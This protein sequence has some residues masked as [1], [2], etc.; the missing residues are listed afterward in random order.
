M[1]PPP[2]RLLGLK[3]EGEQVCPDQKKWETGTQ[4]SPVFSQEGLGSP[5][6]CSC[7]SKVARGGVLW[8]Q[9]L[10]ALVPRLIRQAEADPPPR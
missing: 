9:M 3:A 5:R 2:S 8:E 10:V 4:S 1:G 6:L 7:P